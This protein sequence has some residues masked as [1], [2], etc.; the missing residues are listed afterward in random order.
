MS[1][2]VLDNKDTGD[3]VVVGWD[4]GLQTYFAQ[5]FTAGGRDPSVWMGTQ[6]GEY[7]EPD[8]VIEAVRPYVC[9]FDVNVLESSLR[10]DKRDNSDRIYTIDDSNMD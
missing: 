2:C 4:P 10:I 9:S 1:R 6:Q 3:A 7:R 5:V 8:A